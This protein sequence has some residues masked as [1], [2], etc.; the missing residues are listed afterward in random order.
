MLV[1]HEGEV[2][3]TKLIKIFIEE[4]GNKKNIRSR[5]K[6]L[7]NCFYIDQEKNFKVRIIYVQS[8]YA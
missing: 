2:A 6:E 1:H 7:G 8:L 3:F 4:E 5:I